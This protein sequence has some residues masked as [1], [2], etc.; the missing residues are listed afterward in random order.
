MIKI[1]TLI[2]ITQFLLIGCIS[3]STVV[4]SAKDT[5]PTV[6]GTDLTGEEQTFTKCLTKEKTILVVAFLQWQ[7]VLCDEWYS[8]IEKEMKANSQLAYYEVPTISELNPFTRW[9]IYQGMRGGITDPE[10]RR[11]VVTLHIDKEPFKKSLGIETEETVHIFV[12]DKSGKILLQ[13]K[14]PWSSEKWEQTLGIIKK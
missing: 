2:L 10:M 9:F 4:P 14:G 8:N 1:V 11:Q 5:F 6:T 7:Q 12:V 3:T 13:Q